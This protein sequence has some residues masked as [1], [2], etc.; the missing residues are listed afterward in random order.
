M[1]KDKI[2]NTTTGNTADERLDALLA[3][4]D[5]AGGGNA[6]CGCCEDLPR[7]VM[8][9]CRT[10]RRKRRV[11][12]AVLC[13]ASA[14]AVSFVL[15]SH[16]MR[17]APTSPVIDIP[18]SPSIT[19]IDAPEPTPTILSTSFPATD[20]KAELAQLRKDLSQ[21][22]EAIK[23]SRQQSEYRRRL[24]IYRKLT[25]QPDPFITA[26]SQIE[27]AAFILVSRAEREAASGRPDN[28]AATA[29]R[30]AAELFPGTVWGKVAQ[31]RLD[32]IL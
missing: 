15:I 6:T 22:H 16:A 27:Q 17:S 32:G 18:Q 7:R 30:K 10:R 24:A 3:A 5:P 4:A 19:K 11:V 13:T 23:R 20:A 2:N 29:Y 25:E 9:L 26:Q 31:D 8:D 14:V 12:G 1:T 28:E 21:L